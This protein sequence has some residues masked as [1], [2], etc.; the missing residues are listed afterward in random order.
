ML[1]V[2]LSPTATRNSLPVMEYSGARIIIVT[3]INDVR[4]VFWVLK[5]KKIIGGGYWV[6]ITVAFH[7]QGSVSLPVILIKWC[8]EWYFLEEWC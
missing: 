1:Q 3:E 5:S 2:E 7:P 6:I 8:T 4:T